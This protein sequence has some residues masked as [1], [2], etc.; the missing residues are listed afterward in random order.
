MG[1]CQTKKFL[2]KC[3]IPLIHFL[4]PAW[5]PKQEMGNHYKWS[6]SAFFVCIWMKLKN[7]FFVTI[8]PGT[9]SWCT[10]SNPNTEGWVLL[11]LCIMNKPIWIGVT[12]LT[13]MSTLG[14]VKLLSL[15]LFAALW[16]EVSAQQTVSLTE[17]IRQGHHNRRRKPRKCVG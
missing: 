9:G 10:H 6:I 4:L 11:G 12:I 17:I 16:A 14:Q 15:S 3:Q 5:F 2:T 7:G 1:Y 13:I 8:L